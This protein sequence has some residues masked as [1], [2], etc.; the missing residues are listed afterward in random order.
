VGTCTTSPG[1]A[2]IIVQASCTVDD[3]AIEV[4]YFQ[5]DSQNSMFQAYEGFRL[6]SEIEPDT[7]DCN[8]PTTWPAEAAYNI[9]DQ[10]AGRWLCTEALDQTTIYWTDDR[11]NIL[12]QATH[13]ES[14][15]VRLVDFWT[16]ESGPN[17]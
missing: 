16:E 17:L 14:N 12:S 8:D 2:P 4:T 6:V 13:T 15:Y 7:G 5:Y 1:S 9:G 11:L 3:G 10:P